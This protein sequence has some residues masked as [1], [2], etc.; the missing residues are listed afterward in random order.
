MGAHRMSFGKY[1]CLHCIISYKPFIYLCFLHVQNRGEKK[2][3]PNYLIL[4][5]S[6]NSKLSTL[7]INI[8]CS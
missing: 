7:E 2:A 3:I 1:I 4:F 5:N 6:V 8:E